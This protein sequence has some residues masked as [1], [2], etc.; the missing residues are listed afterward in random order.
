MKALKL[1]VL[2]TIAFLMGGMSLGADSHFFDNEDQVA[3]RLEAPLRTLK[4]QRGDEPQWLKGSVTVEEAGER[5]HVFEVKIKARG[6][7]RRKRS[8]CDFPSYW[9][10]F[11]RKEVKGTIFNGLN[12]VKLVG[13]CRERRKSF[14]PYV[15]K[16]YLAYKT[17]EILSD[18]SFR[19]RLARIEYVDNEKK[20]KTKVYDAFFLEHKSTLQARLGAKEVKDR[21]VLP[22]FYNKVDLCRAEFFQFFVGNSDFSFFASQD[23]C[24]HNAKAFRAKGSSDDYFPVPYDFDMTG[25]VNPP[26]AVPN[27]KLPIDSVTK[28]FYRGLKQDDAVL[29]TV[30]NE[31]LDKRHDIYELWESTELID[32]KEKVRIL[33]FI[34]EFFYILE[35]EDAFAKEIVGRLRSGD[36]LEK[37]ISEKQSDLE[38]VIEKEL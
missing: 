30:I 35:N 20:N 22:S 28:R 13:H 17:F 37:S 3:F 16:E 10:N 19:V 9:L 25:L 31:Y 5:A 7:F 12:K 1:S 21:Y 32:E 24:C 36:V 33:A 15:Y 2:F 23:E 14:E 6:N 4:N 18:R 11:K 29:D 34:D 26:Y 38:S 27:P 8:T